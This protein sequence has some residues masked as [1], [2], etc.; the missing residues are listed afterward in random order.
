MPKPLIP[1]FQRPLITFA[2]DHLIGTGVNRFVIN[3]HRQPELFQS[4]FARN[5][6]A[7]FPV[8]VV[9]EPDLLETGGGIKNAEGRLGGG[10]F[11]TYSGDILTDINLQ[12]LI[13]EHFHR[14][15]DVTLALRHTGLASDVCLR[16]HRVVDIANRYGIAGN[17]ISPISLSGTRRFSSGFRRTKRSRSFRSLRTG[18]VKAERSAAWSLTMENG[19]TS[20]RELNISK[21]IGRSCEK[22]GNRISSK[23]SDGQSASP[24]AQSWSRAHSCA[25]AQSSEQTVA[26]GRKPFWRTQFYGRMQKLLPKAGWRLVLSAPEK[27]SAVFIA[28]STSEFMKTALLLRRTRMHFPRL[29]VAEIEINPIQKG[30]SDRKFYRIRCSPEQALILVKYNLEREENRHYVHIAKFLGEHGIRVPEIYFHDPEEGLIWLEDLGERDLYNYRDEVLAGA[31]RVLRVGTRSNRNLARFTRI[32]LRRDEAAFASR[33]QFRALP[34]G[35]E[36]FLRKLPRSL[37]QDRQDKAG[38]AG[39]LPRIEGNRRAPGVFPESFGAPRFS[40][41][42]YHHPKRPGLPDRFPGN[43]TR[44]CRIRSCLLALRSICRSSG[45]RTRRADCVLSRVSSKTESR[46]TASST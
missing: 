12:P 19:S 36:L 44:P 35:A 2:L 40:I 3:T 4:F 24:A 16:D 30:G 31:P 34:L 42:K 22:I 41:A 7:G 28:I 6:Y 38:A 33:V 37:L 18:S 11:L 46:S 9:H 26:S 8:S 20:L 13:D 21:Y 17:L 27:R 10:P 45:N 5:E 25:A 23:R 14:G 39:R 32:G 43:A 15:N 1:I 29:D